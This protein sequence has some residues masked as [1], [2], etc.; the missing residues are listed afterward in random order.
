MI[1]THA[2]CQLGDTTAQSTPDAHK[3]ECFEKTVTSRHTQH[4]CDAQCS[5]TQYQGKIRLLPVDHV[6]GVSGR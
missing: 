3:E 1:Q 2:C 4:G 5:A 6:A